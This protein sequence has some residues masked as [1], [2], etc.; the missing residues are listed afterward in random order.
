MTFVRNLNCV[1]RHDHFNFL[2][3]QRTDYQNIIISWE[4]K[5]VPWG[6]N[7]IANIYETF[8]I[9]LY[10]TKFLLFCVMD[11]F[12][13]SQYQQYSI[14]V[15][16]RWRRISHEPLPEPKMWIHNSL[17]HKYVTKQQCVLTNLLRYRPQLPKIDILSPSSNFHLII[18]CDELKQHISENSLKGCF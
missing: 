15:Y 8:S 2:W 10:R 18:L 4:M 9:W 11:N 16:N 7:G 1:M 5:C 6:M 13:G 12:V 14:V 3:K 17:R